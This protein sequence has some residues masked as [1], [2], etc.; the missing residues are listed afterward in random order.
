LGKHCLSKPLVFSMISGCHNI[1]CARGRSL[2]R[3]HHYGK[4]ILPRNLAPLIEGQA[5]TLLC[6]DAVEHGSESRSCDCR[7]GS[8]R[9]RFCQSDEERGSRNWRTNSRR[10]VRTLDQSALPIAGH[11]MVFDFRR[12]HMNAVHVR[13]GAAAV[14]APSARA[15]ILTGLAQADDQLGTHLTTRYGVKRGVAGLVA[16]LE[17]RVV[18]LHSAQ[19]ARDLLR[20]VPIAQQPCDVA[21]Q[22][23]IL[24]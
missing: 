24:G 13:N 5:Q 3:Y 10:I 1:N 9:I 21:L 16:D 22:W 19:Y 7:S 18:Q 4:P 12:A 2:P 20:R 14:C 15:P 11:D 23:A 17:R 8:H 6:A